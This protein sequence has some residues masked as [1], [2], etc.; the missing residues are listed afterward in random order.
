MHHLHLG[1]VL[2]GGQQEWRLEVAAGY[3]SPQ[4]LLEEVCLT[5]D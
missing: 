1:A 2:Q 4:R 3:Y 5:T